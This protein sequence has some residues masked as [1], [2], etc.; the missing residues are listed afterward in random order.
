MIRTAVDSDFTAM[1]GGDE[2]A[3]R[4]HSLKNAYGL[5]VPF[6]RYYADDCGGLLSVM[7]GAAVLSYTENREEWAVL[8]R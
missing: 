2:C 6:I 3:I 1:P 7:D 4:I 5:D 8:S